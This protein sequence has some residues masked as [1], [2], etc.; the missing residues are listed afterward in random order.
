[1]LCF[2]Q[3]LNPDRY[4][5]SLQCSPALRTINDDS[6]YQQLDY[7]QFPV[8]V[9]WRPR[10]HYQPLIAVLFSWWK[11][12]LFISC[13]TKRSIAA[14]V[15]LSSR[16]LEWQPHTKARRAR[17]FLALSVT[18]LMQQADLCTCGHGAADTPA[19]PLVHSQ[20]V[21]E[22]PQL[23]STAHTRTLQALDN[24]IWPQTRLLMSFS[25]AS[26]KQTYCSLFCMKHKVWMFTVNWRPPAMWQRAPHQT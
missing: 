23:Y 9:W 24:S 6:A 26:P 13:R 16:K 4:E 8:R 2:P 25:L 10:P 1:M 3:I 18:L 11:L 17:W 22:T 21:E 20:P 19:A 15:L 14:F 5:N 7:Y 12:W